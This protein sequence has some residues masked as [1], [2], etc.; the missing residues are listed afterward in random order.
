[1]EQ[2]SPEEYSGSFAIDFKNYDSAL[3]HGWSN[4]KEFLSRLYPFATA[5]AS[6]SFYAIWDDAS[7]RE[8]N[9]MPIVVFGDEGGEHVIAENLR[10]LIK[11]LTYDEQISVWHDEAYIIK[12]DDD[13]QNSDAELFRNWAKKEFNID[14]VQ[15]DEETEE[16][17]DNA[18]KKHGESFNKW[19]EKF[20]EN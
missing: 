20:F 6:G 16:I 19:K 7:G 9:E 15:S 8:L 5:N 13:F 11:L 17:I 18:Q 12:D 2:S 1:M 4:D 3:Q 14:A 10:E